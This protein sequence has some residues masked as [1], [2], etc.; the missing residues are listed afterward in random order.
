MPNLGTGSA[1]GVSVSR[2]KNI[3][4]L[5]IRNKLTHLTKLMPNLKTDL[6]KTVSNI[7]APQKMAKP[8]AD[9]P[10]YIYVSNQMRNSN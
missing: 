4:V 1:M 9:C 5:I 6:N 8:I 7:K 10:I 3:A 2:S